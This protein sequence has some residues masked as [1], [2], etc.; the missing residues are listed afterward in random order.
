MRWVLAAVM[1]V[2]GAAGAEGGQAA[3]RSMEGGCSST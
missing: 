1:A 3:P 2:L